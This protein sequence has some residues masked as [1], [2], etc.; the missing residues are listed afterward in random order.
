MLSIATGS[1]PLAV[2]RHAADRPGLRRDAQ[3]LGHQGIGNERLG[4]QHLG[5]GNAVRLGHDP[6]EAPDTE[7][8]SRLGHERTAAGAPVDVALAHERL[9]RVPRRHP[10]DL[11][12]L[13]QDPLGRHQSVSIQAPARDLVA[14]LC[15]DPRIERGFDRA[16]ARRWPPTLITP[17][18]RR[19]GESTRCA[20]HGGCRRVRASLPYPSV[21]HTR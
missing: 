12:A 21:V 1:P 6:R 4:C 8:Q 13:A 5:P 15:G 9:E 7:A 20:R 16:R 2:P 10:A 19:N 14:Q 11:I 17:Q 18:S 3:H